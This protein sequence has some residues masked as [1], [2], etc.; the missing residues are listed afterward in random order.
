MTPA[1]S[2]RKITSHYMNTT[3]TTGTTSSPSRPQTLFL[4]L[5]LVIALVP[6]SVDSRI[7][8]SKSESRRRGGGT[9]QT[10]LEVSSK[11]KLAPLLG[12]T[13]ED[14]G[15]ARCN[16]SPGQTGYHHRF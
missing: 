7:F 13:Q 1:T 14:I 9:L 4:V 15:P 11:G 3:A 8:A 2:S 5:L 10:D 16:E 12:V 6:S